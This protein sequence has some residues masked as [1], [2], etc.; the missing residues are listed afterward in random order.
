MGAGWYR[1]ASSTRPAD[2][3]ARLLVLDRSLRDPL[4]LARLGHDVDEGGLLAGYGS[5]SDAG[6]SPGLMHGEIGVLLVS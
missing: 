4:A 6:E 3:R 1:A 5:L 2:T